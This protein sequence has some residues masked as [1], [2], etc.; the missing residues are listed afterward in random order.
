MPSCIFS[1][2][3]LYVALS[4]NG[5][6]R[7]T[8]VFVKPDEQQG[9][10][11]DGLAGTSTLNIVYPEALA[12]ARDSLTR[13][14]PHAPPQFDDGDEPDPYLADAAV[15]RLPPHNL[16][17]P[18]NRHSEVNARPPAPQPFNAEYM[19]MNAEEE[20]PGVVSAAPSSVLAVDDTCQA[21]DFEEDML[22]LEAWEAQAARWRAAVQPMLDAYGLESAQELDDS[23]LLE[24][25]NSAM[26][27]ATTWEALSF[28][29]NIGSRETVCPFVP[30]ETRQFQARMQ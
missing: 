24:L 5:D 4:R 7:L 21:R 2:G 20:M 26:P 12:K 16:P 11:V 14:S 9:E 3:Q 27:M 8:V 1:H 18:R 22:N 10:G 25:A 28:C 17:P 6:P 19:A 23:G 29:E 13:A 15:G 30:V